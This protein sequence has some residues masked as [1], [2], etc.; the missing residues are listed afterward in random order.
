MIKESDLVHK[1]VLRCDLLL[2]AALQYQ[3]PSAL[4][5]VAPYL[6]IYHRHL[7]YRLVQSEHELTLHNF[8]VGSLL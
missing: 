8:R 5:A 3:L 4:L 6:I 1:G 2:I 7:V